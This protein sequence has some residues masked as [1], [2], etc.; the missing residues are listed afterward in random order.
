M[1]TFYIKKHGEYI[2]YIF[3]FNEPLKLR[4]TKLKIT[5]NR[6]AN[7]Q[8]HIIYTEK[9]ARVVLQLEKDAKLI[10]VIG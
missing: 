10:P 4:N 8:P 2:N 7:L 9:E 5:Q 3:P 6:V 1:R